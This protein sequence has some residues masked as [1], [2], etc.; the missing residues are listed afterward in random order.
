M[1]SLSEKLL[2]NKR[3]AFTSNAFAEDTFEVVTMQGYESISRPFRFELTLVSDDADIDFEQML[4]SQ[5]AFTI[6]APDGKQPTPY[7]GMVAEF[8]QLHESGGYIF[9]RVVMVPRIWQLSLYQ[10]SEVYLEEKPIPALIKQVLESANFNSNDFEI[11]TNGQYRDRSFVC[12]YQESHLDF[13]S[14]W[15]EKEGMYY[16]FDHD[17][18][19]DKLILADDKVMHAPD[20][21]Q[22][23]YRPVDELDT[24]VAPDSVQSFSCRQKP[25]PKQVILQDFNYRKASTELKAT[26]TVSEKG[27]GEVMFY[28]ENFRTNEEGER[29]ANLRA[30]E[31]LARS[32]IF[33]G[34]STAVGLRCGF[35]M[36]LNHHFRDAFN[37][38]YLITEIEHQGSQAGALLNGIRTP[39]NADESA[40]VTSYSNSFQAIAADTQFRPERITPKPKVAGTMNAVIDAEGSG[41][42]ADLDEYGQYKVQLP[43][44]RTDKKENK[45]STRI[46][47][48]SPYSGNEHGMHFPL[49]KKSEVLL[50]F[51][52][53]DPDQPVILGAVPNSENKNVVSSDQA[54]IN[55]IKTAA[56]NVLE[57]SDVKGEEGVFLSSPT[58]NSFISI[59]SLS[60]SDSVVNEGL[61]THTEGSKVEFVK[62]SQVSFSLGSDYKVGLGTESA[63]SAGLK[64]DYSISQILSVGLSS[65]LSA[66]YGAGL[67]LHDATSEDISV[68]KQI[69]AIESVEI[70]AGL[71]EHIKKNLMLLNKIIKG[72]LSVALGVSAI[73]SGV[74]AAALMSEVHKKASENTGDKHNTLS[75]DDKKSVESLVLQMGISSA[76]AASIT[77]L[78]Y[79]YIRYYRS[80]VNNQHGAKLKLNKDGVF[81]TSKKPDDKSGEIELKPE[82]IK[83]NVGSSYISIDNN[84]IV[85]EASGRKIKISNDGIDLFNPG[86]SG[87]SLKSGFKLGADKAEIVTDGVTHEFSA[88][89]FF[90]TVDIKSNNLSTAS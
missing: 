45:G 31:I 89:L 69:D 55:K 70:S 72:A 67:V 21:V 43:F 83:L 24:G 23:N 34:E 15:L 48:A 80:A 84:S 49:H 52:D 54:E 60:T 27:I 81:L 35:F 86:D 22:V 40:A 19:N 66:E 76:L 74:I 2:A 30:Q 46:R 56:G 61:T 38:Q 51:A 9:Y 87:S 47:M 17:Q 57:M 64:E 78:L 16:W 28:G 79:G 88:S 1:T 33:M 4:Q 42:Y 26:A 44:D 68:E 82:S 8:D 25:L 65:K 75:H 14:R 39:Y 11:K 58:A 90:T 63:L 32:K 5:V 37:S 62:G 85:L 53:G 6:Y 41:E 12:Q 73:K 29:Y 10:I 3:F 71:P 36:Q 7:Y 77:G 13:I 18:K 20:A 59:G 50:S